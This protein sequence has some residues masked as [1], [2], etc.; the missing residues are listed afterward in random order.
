MR[1]EWNESAFK[2]IRYGRTSEI[3]GELEDHANKVADEANATG[4]GTYVTGSRPGAARPQGRHRTSV[5]TGDARAMI[6][7]ARNNTLLRA[8]G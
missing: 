8:L 4:A 6:D 5:V 3:I 1:I 7:N 2:D